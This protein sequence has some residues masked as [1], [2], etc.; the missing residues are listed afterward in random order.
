MAL[1]GDVVRF[2]SSDVNMVHSYASS[3][4]EKLFAIGVV[5]GGKWW[6]SGGYLVLGDTS[7]QFPTVAINVLVRVKHVCSSGLVYLLVMIG[8][9]SS[10]S[11][12]R[13]PAAS[14]LMAK[15]DDVDD[16]SE[17]DEGNAMSCV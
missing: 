6:S 14:K 13:D 4:I 12:Q 7:I 8:G 5:C 11:L 17:E 10:P 9:V 3:C 1:L 16:Y 2:L 15:K